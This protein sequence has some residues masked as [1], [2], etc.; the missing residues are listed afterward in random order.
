[1]VISNAANRVYLDHNATTPIAAVVRD[2][3]ACALEVFGNP[4]SIHDEGRAARDLVE[5]ARRR[6]AAALFADVTDVVFTSGG[7][8]ADCL[9]I[10]GL[11]RLAAR[12]GLPARAV[13]T[14]IEHPAV[15]GVLGALADA[16]FCVEMCRVDANGSVDLDDL[17]VRVRHGVGVVAVALVNHEL[18]TLQ[19]IQEIAA[20][21][22]GSGAL[23]HVDAVSA[24]G[25]LPVDVR[26]LGADAIAISSHKIYGPKGA[27]ALWVRPD[28]DLSP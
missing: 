23:L 19:P 27:G 4:S 9:G 13:T 26:A 6:V 24:F 1:M 10:S 14:P 7:T 3:M 20:I 2:E 11:A 22:R 25:K 16:G 18:G 5:V 12:I 15:S 8:E 28:R 17:S 21:A